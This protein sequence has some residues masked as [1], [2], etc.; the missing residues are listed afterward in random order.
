MSD[1]SNKPNSHTFSVLSWL[2]NVSRS[3]YYEWLN[4]PQTERKNM[5]FSKLEKIKKPPDRYSQS[6]AAAT[7]HPAKPKLWLVLTSIP[8]IIIVSIAISQK[9][10]LLQ[11]TTDNTAN[12][13]IKQVAAKLKVDEQSYQQ[14]QASKEVAANSLKI[15]MVKVPPGCFQLG[16]DDG[17]KNEQPVHQV[18]FSQSYELGKYEVTQAQWQQVMGNN[19]SHFKSSNNKPVENVSWDD[20]QIFIRNLNQ[21]TGLNYRLPTEAEWEFGCRSGGKNQKYCGSDNAANIAWYADNSDSITHNVGQKNPSELGFYDMSG[22]VWEWVQDR[23]DSSYYGNSPINNPQGPLVGLLRIIR[24]G[25]WSSEVSS[26]RS[27]NRNST[28]TG[29]RII[30]LGFRLARTP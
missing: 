15:S 3:R 27:S 16:S 24:G 23:Y 2:M 4:S 17:S 13:T 25:S 30:N 11:W 7:S 20:V 22:N 12:P 29:N 10:T 1:K 9:Q 26:M 5:R 18:C 14:K 28:S 21:Q 8:I 19:P 6:A